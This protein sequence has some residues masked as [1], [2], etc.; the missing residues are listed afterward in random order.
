MHR[1]LKINSGH[2]AHLT[3]LLESW[4]MTQTSLQC[5]AGYWRRIQIHWKRR[6]SPG[7]SQMKCSLR[8]TFSLSEF[9]VCVSVANEKQDQGRKPFIHKECC[10]S[11]FTFYMSTEKDIFLYSNLTFRHV[12]DLHLFLCWISLVESW[13]DHCCGGPPTSPHLADPCLGW[14]HCPPDPHPLPGMRTWRMV[15]ALGLYADQEY[16]FLA[17]TYLF[18]TS[19]FF[20]QKFCKA[21]MEKIKWTYYGVLAH[22]QFTNYMPTEI[23]VWSASKV[24]GISVKCFACV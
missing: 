6:F 2:W 12:I 10:F 17:V 9:L 20:F 3:K 22:H 14:L 21:V 4:W 11:V 8:Y 13:L 5:W 1:H 15:G 23:T 18:S 19:C 24:Y 7:W 16:L